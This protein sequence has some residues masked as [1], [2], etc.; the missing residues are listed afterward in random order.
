MPGSVRIWP[1]MTSSSPASSPGL[2][3]S[4]R[5]WNGGLR[6]DDIEERDRGSMSCSYAGAEAFVLVQ[7]LQRRTTGPV[8]ADDME[9]S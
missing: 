3:S 7:L 1:M 8:S 6:C 4:S 2:A 9:Q 5:R